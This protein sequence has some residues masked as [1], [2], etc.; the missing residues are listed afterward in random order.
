VAREELLSRLTTKG[1][2]FLAL[3][4]KLDQKTS[5]NILDRLAKHTT[6]IQSILQ[7][8][9]DD[10][11]EDQIRNNVSQSVTH[12]M[13]SR[14]AGSIESQACKFVQ[15]GHELY[16]GLFL[17]PQNDESAMLDMVMNLSCSSTYHRYW[18]ECRIIHYPPQLVNRRIS[19]FE[20]N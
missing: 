11:T 7:R 15:S 6:R 17:P 9:H 10:A 16:I 19:Y 1:T 13:I 5:V 12:Q 14:L 18:G 2:F 20:S 8:S 4:Y 3:N